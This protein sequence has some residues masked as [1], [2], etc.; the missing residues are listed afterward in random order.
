MTNIFLTDDQLADDCFD[1]TEIGQTNP[2]NGVACSCCDKVIKH[3]I[4]VHLHVRATDES[5]DELQKQ[6]GDYQ[7]GKN[8]CI[9]WEC[10]LK[11]LGAKP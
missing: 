2:F 7:L 3:H 11:S 1:Q 5:R 9:C 10:Y 8:Y 6:M 4:A